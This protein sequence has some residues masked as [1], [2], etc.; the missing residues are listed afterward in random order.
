MLIEIEIGASK[1]LVK[2]DTA[3]CPTTFKALELQESNLEEFLRNNIQVL[4][5][6][7]DAQG[8]ASESLLVVGQQVKSLEG[9]RNDLV[10]VDGNGCLTLIEI[11]RDVDDIKH[12]R[13]AFE[14]QA[15]R[16]AAN[17]A[18]IKTPHQLV[19]FIYAP[20]VEKHRQDAEFAK[21]VDFTAVEIALRKLSE[22]LDQ[23]NVTSTFNLSQRI[24]LVASEFDSQTLSAVAW[25]IANNVDISCFTLTPG[26]MLERYF[27]QIEKIL[28]LPLLEDNY[29]GFGSFNTAD[30]SSKQ[31]ASRR[32]RRRNEIVILNLLQEGFLCV[33]EILLIHGKDDSRAKIVNDSQVEFAGSIMSFN[34]WGKSVKGW[35]TINIYDWAENANGERLDQLRQQLALKR[36]EI[37]RANLIEIESP[38]ATTL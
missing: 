20:Y 35:S 8:T 10:A 11:K 4:F 37:I 27:I 31:R 13:E 1:N 34:D 2:K 33:G 29:V 6:S 24:V 19:D 25:L 23:N 3:F 7:E 15:I 32:S 12:R 28:P 22:F 16:Y 36:A 38:E 30:E 26:K 21:F 17:L 18:T 5:S 9:G 14:F